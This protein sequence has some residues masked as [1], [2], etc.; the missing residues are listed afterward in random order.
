LSFV[1]ARHSSACA[2]GQFITCDVY[3]ESVLTAS[4]FK[5]LSCENVGDALQHLAGVYVRNGQVALRDVAADKVVIL[6]DGQR[7]NTAQGGGVDIV[8][9]PIDNVEKVEVIRGGNSALYGADAVG[10]VIKITSKSRSTQSASSAVNANVYGTIGSFYERIAGVG[11][12]QSIDKFSYF[13]NYK[14]STSRGDFSYIDPTTNAST[15]WPNNDQASHDLF[16]K[17][18]Y[19]IMRNRI[20]P[21]PVGCTTRRSA[22]RDS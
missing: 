16:V 7:L 1:L 10:G 6:F 4:D 14:R 9:L 11:F 15:T 21:S 20:L 12:S 2:A 18:S 3:V 19:V 13:V 17:G 22:P 5:K 8:S